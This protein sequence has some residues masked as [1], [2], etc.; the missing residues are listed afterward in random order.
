MKRQ[1][2]IDCKTAYSVLK[3]LQKES[4]YNNF[5]L[6]RSISN[7]TANDFSLKSSIWTTRRILAYLLITLSR[8]EFKPE[9]TKRLLFCK[10]FKVKNNFKGKQSPYCGAG[11]A[12][13]V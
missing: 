5:E 3:F 12:Q 9:R 1:Q 2:F 7:L 11:I 4:E 10:I 6:Q 13:S 8:N